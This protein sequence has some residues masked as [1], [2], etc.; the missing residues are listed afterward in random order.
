MHAQVHAEQTGA[1]PH[2]TLACRGGLGLR[3]KRAGRV[4]LARPQRRERGME[5]AL[6][7]NRCGRGNHHAQ[8][9]A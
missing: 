3:L 5:L 7:G 2:E 8:P 1:Q 9:P 4:L 6:G